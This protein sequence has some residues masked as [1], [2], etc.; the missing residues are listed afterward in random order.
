M[1]LLTSLIVAPLIGAV[2]IALLPARRVH[3]ARVV[4]LLTSGLALTLAISLLSV[5]D[6]STLSE[7]VKWNPRMGVAYSV[8]I[9]GFSLPMVLL[10]TLL[11]LVAI[12]ASAN[13]TERARGYYL[14]LLLLESAV[15]G[16]FL[17]RD[18]VLFYIFWEMTL[19]P[20][21]FLIDRWGGKRRHVAALNFVLYTLGG[22]V[23]LLVALLVLYD[24]LQ[25][26]TFDMEIIMQ[27]ARLLSGDKQLYIF[28]GFLIGFGVKMPIFP[29]HGWLPVAHVEAPSPVSILLS[30]ILL[31]MGSYGIIRAT[32]MLPAAVMNLRDWLAGLALF[33]LLYG[34]FLAWRQFDLKSMIAYS[35]VSH[36]GVV[37][38]GIATLNETGLLGA[39][40][41]MTAHGLVAGSLFF[42]IGALYDRTHTRDVRVYS[43]LVRKAPGF[44]LFTCLAFISA[45]GIPGT[46]GFMAE[47]H[48]LFG[49]FV[50][51]KWAVVAISVSL[52]VNAAYSTRTVGRMFT[53]PINEELEHITDIKMSEM[54][55]VGVLSGLVI[56]IGIFPAQ[57][58]TIISPSVSQLSKLFLHF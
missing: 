37:L 32:E 12:S 28:L 9:D 3:W 20:L 15:L 52:L 43:S 17:A 39:V 23:F 5:S 49:G 8:G 48:V 19:I 35:S 24:T 36:M 54:I 33:S 18:W 44:A 7:Y 30:G 25:V 57:L 1:R 4:A 27:S 21:F 46:A 58:L 13:I 11:C 16:V 53:G 14:L 40:M 10:A 29:L 42:L 51:W 2:I 45:V 50:V 41:Q 26:H 55:P 31:K 22:S 6:L 34:G 56:F 38:L 47:L